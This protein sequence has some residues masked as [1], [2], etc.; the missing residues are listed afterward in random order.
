VNV[1]IVITAT[2]TTT[3]NRLDIMSYS[4]TLKQN[5]CSYKIT[6]ASSV[7]HS[8]T[9]VLKV[10]TQ[11]LTILLSLAENKMTELECATYIMGERQ[12]KLLSFPGLVLLVSIFETKVVSWCNGNN[13]QF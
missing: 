10:I 8:S 6:Y 5:L 13:T 11:K 4:N 2:T 7:T 3:C 12:S 9:K 1:A